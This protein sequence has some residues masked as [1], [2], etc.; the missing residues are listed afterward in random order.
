M[1]LPVS[2]IVVNIYEEYFEEMALGPQCP[3]LPLNG[4]YMWMMS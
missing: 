1:G 4:K 2:P 3:Y